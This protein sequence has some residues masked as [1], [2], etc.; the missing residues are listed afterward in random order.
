LSSGRRSAHWSQRKFD[1]GAPTRW[2]ERGRP[3]PR[4]CD[5]PRQCRQGYALLE[6]VVGAPDSCAVIDRAQSD[7]HRSASAHA[8][9]VALRVAQVAS[10]RAFLSPAGRAVVTRTLRCVVTTRWGGTVARAR[11]AGERCWDEQCGGFG[12]CYPGA[13]TGGWSRQS[14]AAITHSSQCGVATDGRGFN[15]IIR[16]S[17]RTR[18]REHASR[19]PGD[20]RFVRH[21]DGLRV[22]QT[23]AAGDRLG[24]KIST[25]GQ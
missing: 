25:T 6:S 16:P 17:P 24:R 13:L 14:I 4:T 12:G 23:G 7:T 15:I 8:P 5:M 2:Q 20:F 3:T 19:H 22:P 11:P 9:D 10:S 1:R 21:R 18:Q